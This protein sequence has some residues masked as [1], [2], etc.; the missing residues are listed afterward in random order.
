MLGCPF[1]STSLSKDRAMHLVH[2]FSTISVLITV[3]LHKD[4]FELNVLG[5]TNSPSITPFKYVA[6]IADLPRILP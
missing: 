3:I 6:V 2:T 5:V 4:L 1:R